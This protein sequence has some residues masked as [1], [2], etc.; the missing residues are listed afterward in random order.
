VTTSC[1]QTSPDCRGSAERVE[2]AYDGEGNRTQLKTT[3]ASGSATTVDFAYQGSTLVEERTNGV[4]TRQYTVD[5]TGTIIKLTIPAGQANAGTYLVIWNGHGDA[6]ALYRIETSGT[7]TLANSFSYSSWGAPT[8]ATHNGI[9]DLGFRFLYVGQYGVAWDNAF[10]LGLH[11]MRARHYA[12]A[13]G[14]FL[15]HDPTRAEDSH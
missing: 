11:Y 12:P 10:G 13:L 14:R 1:A 7:L 2:L 8:T 3:P 5:E 6:L 4:L 15:Q 9:G